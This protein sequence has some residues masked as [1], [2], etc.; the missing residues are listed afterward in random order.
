MKQRKRCIVICQGFY[1]WLKKGP[2]GKDKTPYFVKRKDG[3][4]MCFAGLWDVVKYEDAED[5]LYSYTI[6]TTQSNQ[7]LRFLH[8][9]MPVILDAGSEEMKS[10]LDPGRDKWSKELQSFL[11]PYQ[12]EL[13]CYPV[14]KEVGKVSNNSPSFIVPID[15]KENKKNIARFFGSPKEPSEK[16]VGKATTNDNEIVKDDHDQ[17]EQN[18]DRL[19]QDQR[20]TEHNAPVPIPHG[21]KREHSAEE[22]TPLKTVKIEDS[23]TAGEGREANSTPSRKTRS[24]TSNAASNAAFRKHESPK[25]VDD[26]HRITSFFGK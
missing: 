12:G 23:S 14:S 7:Q 21:T 18:D 22:D 3:E 10:W 1:E 24:A 4:L 19:T 8:D 2:G 11:Q 25:T 15:S 20:D 5:K 26:S 17:P 9:R 16:Q 13:E 6:I